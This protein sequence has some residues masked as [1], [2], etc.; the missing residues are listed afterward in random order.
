MKRNRCN[1]KTQIIIDAFTRYDRYVANSPI[2]NGKISGYKSY[3]ALSWLFTDN[4][5]CGFIDKKIFEKGAEF[6][7]SDYIDV[8]LDI[9]VLFIV[10]G[11]NMIE[12][13]QRLHSKVYKRRF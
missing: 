10:R 5:R 1:E 8:L 3:R 4:N 12:I 6:S 11:G 7:F 9:P 13:N 2:Y